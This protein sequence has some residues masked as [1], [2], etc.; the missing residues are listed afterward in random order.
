MAETRIRQRVQLTFFQSRDQLPLPVQTSPFD[1][2]QLQRLL[3]NVLG[4]NFKFLD[5][6]QG[7]P[8]SP[9]RSFTPMAPV[10]R[11]RP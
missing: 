2:H 3:G 4:A 11:G 6:L 9:N 5:Q 10:M 8:E 7:A 1:F